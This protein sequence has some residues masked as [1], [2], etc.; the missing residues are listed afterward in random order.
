MSDSE[1]PEGTEFWEGPPRDPSLPVLVDRLIAWSH[2]QQPVTVFELL[3]MIRCQLYRLRGS[4]T[5][6]DLAEHIMDFLNH[7]EHHIRNDEWMLTAPNGEKLPLVT[8]EMRA[9]D[10][11]QAAMGDQ[12]M[13]L[14][15]GKD[16]FL[17]EELDPN[18]S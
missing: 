9:M 2:R 5:F 13:R 17:I 15:I 8:P 10:P 6:E 16:E 14:A 1:I 7:N 12:L 18:G 4:L 11:D 3:N